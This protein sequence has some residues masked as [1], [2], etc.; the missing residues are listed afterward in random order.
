MVRFIMDTVEDIPIY[1]VHIYIPIWLDLLL[2]EA[3]KL[4]HRH[5]HLHSNMVRFIITEYN[6]ILECFVAIYIPI[7]L[8]LLWRSMSSKRLSSMYLHS[9]M[10][11]FIMFIGFSRKSHNVPFTF[12]YG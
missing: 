1:A 8:D 10:V 12:Q 3:C 11:R 5:L 2:G 9:N 6:R 4:F 7:W